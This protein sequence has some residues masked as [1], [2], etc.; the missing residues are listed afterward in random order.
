M[1]EMPPDLPI[2]YTSTLHG[3]IPVYAEQVLVCTG[4]GD[5]G[6][7]IYEEEGGVNLAS[8]LKAVLG[9]GGVYDDVCMRIVKNGVVMGCL[10]I[11]CGT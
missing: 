6:S 11:G 4:R 5:W 9:R 7:N 8:E 10:L 2:D 3:K 1:P